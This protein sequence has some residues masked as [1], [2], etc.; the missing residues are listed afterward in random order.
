MCI[1]CCYPLPQLFM[2]CN[3]T[4]LLL[5]IHIHFSCDICRRIWFCDH[6]SR[7]IYQNG[8]WYRKKWKDERATRCRPFSMSGVCFLT[9]GPR[10]PLPLFCKAGNY[11]FQN[12]LVCVV[13]GHSLPMRKICWRVGRWKWRGSCWS[14]QRCLQLD[15][16]KDEIHS[17]F[18]AKIWE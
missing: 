9:F 2:Y 7:F 5:S 1:P 15:A 10:T 14:F 6:L 13:L 12:P 4:L 11:I 18:L 8:S 17:G 3:L 16:W